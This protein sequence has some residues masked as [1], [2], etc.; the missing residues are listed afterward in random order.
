MLAIDIADGIWTADLWCRK[1]PL[2]QLRNHHCPTIVKVKSLTTN[3]IWTLVLKI[4]SQMVN[5]VSHKHGRVNLYKS[6]RCSSVA[7]VH[8]WCF[9][10]IHS[11]WRLYLFCCGCIFYFYFFCALKSNKKAK[12]FKSRKALSQPTYF[13]RLRYHLGLILQIF[14]DPLLQ[15]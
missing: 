11:R 3:G 12:H 5:H 2:Y 13:W 4:C 8:C 7:W 15:L 10:F 1:Q 14:A 6:C 9:L